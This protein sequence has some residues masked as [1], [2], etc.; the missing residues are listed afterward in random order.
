MA[1]ASDYLEEKILDHLLGRTTYTA[2]ATLYIGLWTTVLDDAATGSTAGE[3]SGSG[4]ARQAVANTSANWPSPSAGSRHN[5]NAI[6]FGQAQSVWGTVASVAVLDASSGG[7]VMFH[8]A[9][10]PRIF[11]DTYDPVTFRTGSVVIT[12]D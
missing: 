10:S 2:P 7:N 5:A 9:L 3:V 12:C 11:I 1:G 8:Q 4:Y 6:A